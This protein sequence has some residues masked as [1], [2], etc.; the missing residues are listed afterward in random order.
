VFN[1]GPEELLLILVIALIVFGPKRL[2]EIGRTIGKSLREFRRASEGIRDEV[3]RHLDLDEQEDDGFTGTYPI[4]TNGRVAD[5]D[6]GATEPGPHDQALPSGNGPAPEE[7]TPEATA[8][9]GP[10]AA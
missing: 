8:E 7:T 3:R 2:P 10:P 1:I 4:P 6:A 5:G 9:S